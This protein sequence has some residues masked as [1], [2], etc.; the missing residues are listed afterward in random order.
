MAP[1]NGAAYVGKSA[2]AHKG[3]MHVAA[4]RRNIDSY[5]HIDPALVGNETRVLVSDLSGRGNMLSKAEE[6]GL[7]LSSD[8]AQTVLGTDQGAGKPGLCVRGG[9]S[10]RH[11]ADAPPAAGLLSRRLN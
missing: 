9:G 10:V 4:I 2:F 1:N 11:D 6:F 7:D 3:G 8:D 5:Q